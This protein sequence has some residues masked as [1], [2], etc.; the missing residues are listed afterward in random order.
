MLPT[1]SS[2]RVREEVKSQEKPVLR[3]HSK[4][5]DGAI[6][7]QCGSLADE[8]LLPNT[9]TREA[10]TGGT[11]L[12]ASHPF[13]CVAHYNMESEALLLSSNEGCISTN[14]AP[15]V[16]EAALQP[17]WQACDITHLAPTKLPV[18]KAV[19]AWERRPTSPFFKSKGRSTK[20]WKRVSTS[21]RYAPNAPLEGRSKKRIKR[22]SSPD[23]KSKPVKKRCV[24]SGYGIGATV[25][26]WDERQSPTRKIVTRSG[27]SAAQNF[28]ALSDQKGLSLGDAEEQ[29]YLTVE[30]LEENGA[31]REVSAG[32]ADAQ[33]EWEDDSD[34]GQE[35]AGPIF[36]AQASPIGAP[37][38]QKETNGAPCGRDIEGGDQEQETRGPTGSPRTTL[39]TASPLGSNL[40]AC[41]LPDITSD[42]Q[43]QELRSGNHADCRLP[44]GFVSPFKQRIRRKSRGFGISERRQTVPS[45]FAPAFLSDENAPRGPCSGNDETDDQAAVEHNE[46]AQENQDVP[47]PTHK[48]FL[49]DEQDNEEWEDV[50]MLEQDD[51]CSPSREL[52]GPETICHE[53]AIDAPFTDDSAGERNVIIDEALVDH[54]DQAHGPG[55]AHADA[56]LKFFGHSAGIPE[57]GAQLRRS[58][59]RQSSSPLKRRS[60][61]SGSDASHLLAFTP[62]KHAAVQFSPSV[63]HGDLAESLEESELHSGRC[64]SPIEH[65]NS[66][67]PEEGQ[68]SLQKPSKPRVSDDTALLQAFLNRAA[69]SRTS[70]SVL[71]RKRESITNRRDS[72][73]VREALATPVKTDVLGDLDP[74][75]PSPR[76][77]AVE[78][79]DRITNGTGV[80][81]DESQQAAPYTR[82]LRS[83]RE[84]RR[85]APRGGTTTTN[86]APNKISIRSNPDVVLKRSEA[87]ALAQLTRSNTQK[88]KGG[89]VLPPARL[90]RLTSPVGSNGSDAEA[91]AT[92]KEGAAGPPKPEHIKGVK[93]AEVLV[94]F[95]QS[96]DVLGS[97]MLGDESTAPP[98]EPAILPDAATDPVAAPPPPSETPSKPKPR[99]LNPPRTAAAHA[100]SSCTAPPRPDADT[101][102]QSPRTRHRKKPPPRPSRYRPAA[103]APASPHPPKAPPSCL[104]AKPAKPTK[105]TT[106]A[107][108]LR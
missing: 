1:S 72:D 64:L 92:D 45:M 62:L 68:I 5:H 35:I 96:G 59:R 94:E 80:V 93:W 17:T 81:P 33:E 42:N 41:S 44:E 75:S 13:T 27:A 46:Q 71:T 10:R 101:N 99:R 95:A 66:A 14:I 104:P 67:P 24:D 61:T 57:L 70:Q 39:P 38:L 16:D 84:R 32:E 86:A 50:E 37:Q 23:A 15:P 11:R 6:P 107:L 97:S 3:Q 60:M 4:S 21:Q 103:A 8:C 98:N 25:L 18:A 82:T 2:Q 49:H 43:E 36:I 102:A 30:I 58:P 29:E 79:E 7:S 56:P 63:R 31:V 89:A 52:S 28:Q 91:I 74:N 90:T 108:P 12:K 48:R 88:N 100:S 9:K 51:V 47:N 69:E 55:A 34:Q 19:R 106:R 22:L 54:S 83:G 76:K 85:V 87:Q 53:A 105:P 77:A 20:L 73:A 40:H 26:Q 65:S 78:V